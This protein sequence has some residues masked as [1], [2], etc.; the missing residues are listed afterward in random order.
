M[1]QT[2]STGHAAEQR[3]KLES[4][5]RAVPVEIKR[6]EPMARHTSLKV[7]GPAEIMAFPHRPEDLCE[8]LRSAKTAKVPLFFLG[9]GTNLLVKDGGIGGV[10]I[11][12]SRFSRIEENGEEIYVEAGVPCPRLVRFSLEKSLSGLEFA[13]G[14][15]GTL[16]GVVVMNAGTP[17]GEIAQVVKRVRVMTTSGQIVEIGRDEIEF[18]YRFSRLPS[19]ILLGAWL[20]L[21]KAKRG[22][23]QERVDRYAKRRN[24]TQP[25]N[26][27][28][29]GS[30]FKNPPGDHAGRL[31]ETAGLK[32]T[33]LGDAQISEKHANFI[34]NR[35]KATARDVIKLIKLIG[36]TVEEQTGITLELEIRIVGRD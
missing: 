14:I 11:K 2:V 28:N 23:I 22:E 24:A 29:A 33:R 27:P 31:I 19:G 7:G 26:L 20:K 18:D 30:I 13:Y 1:M 12:L 34:V 21:K 36:R 4:M 35:G 17:E 3:E 15:P 16:G 6:S 9:G 8:I 25:V 10:V 5:L 32:G